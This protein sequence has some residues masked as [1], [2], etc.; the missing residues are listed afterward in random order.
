M[1]DFNLDAFEK[2][3]NFHIIP[4]GISMPIK[5][6]VNCARVGLSLKKIDTQKPKFW[7]ADY[8]F[9]SYPEFNTKQKDLIILSLIRQR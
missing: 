6:I 8:R 7:L 5:E 4:S 9:L 1:K 3:S 2:N